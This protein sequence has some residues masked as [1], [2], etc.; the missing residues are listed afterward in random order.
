MRGELEYLA[1]R[2]SRDVT[3][4]QEARKRVAKFPGHM[5]I[6]V[7]LNLYSSEPSFLL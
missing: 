1:E 7:Y 4:N 5:T 6:N 2:L 3:A